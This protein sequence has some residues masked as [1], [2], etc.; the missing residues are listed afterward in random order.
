MRCLYTIFLVMVAVPVQAE[1]FKCTAA[2]GKVY[3]Q[4]EQCAEDKQQQQ[5]KIIKTDPEKINAAQEE[6][7]KR[8]QA[9]KDQ[10]Q[11][12]QDQA[13]QDQAAA[14]EQ[15]QQVPI[16]SQQPYVM[17]E[18]TMQKVISNRGRSRGLYYRQS[19]LLPQQ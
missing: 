8:I 19:D 12:T 2:S 15:Q 14:M 5:V 6:S 4:S 16:E 18:A 17:D 7:A 1:V 11:A 13:E 3:Y 9:W 10:E